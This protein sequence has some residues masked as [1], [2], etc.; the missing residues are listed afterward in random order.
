MSVF[1]SANQTD[2]YT[3][4]YKCDLT[5][6]KNCVINKINLQYYNSAC[7][8][9]QSNYLIGIYHVIKKYIFQQFCI[10]VGLPWIYYY[11]MQS[12]I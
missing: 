11:P 12:I 4:V 7:N 3:I 2:Q 9:S 5:C 6:N 8:L 10:Y 1:I